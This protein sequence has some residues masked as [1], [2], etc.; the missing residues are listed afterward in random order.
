MKRLIIFAM[1]L[2]MISSAS[3][4]CAE[5]WQCTD[6]SKCSDNAAE[7]TCFDFNGCGTADTKPL[8]SAG[9]TE[10]YPYCYDSI[11]NQDETDT[12]CGGNYCESCDIGK[13][14]FM[15]SDCEIDS[16][17]NQVCSFGETAKPAPAISTSWLLTAVIILLSAA[18]VF[19]IFA[20]M[21]RLKRHKTHISSVK[22]E[23]KI[24]IPMAKKKSRMNRFTENFNGYLKSMKP[25][26]RM[27]K[28]NPKGLLNKNPYKKQAH[29]VK[30]FVLD[31]LKEVYD[32]Q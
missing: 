3:A 31:N 30:E 27:R 17:I 18:I 24:S 14:C 25:D 23:I 15:N 9:C 8:E 4:L 7:R 2:L 19:V 16:C 22:E 6:W 1:L 12:D 28:E 21:K 5:N 26:K 11:L 20:I 32:E 10:I 29:P 13:T